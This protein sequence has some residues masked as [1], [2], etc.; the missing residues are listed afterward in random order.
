M[1]LDESPD[2]FTNDEQ[3]Y[4]T[5][6]GYVMNE[7]H[8]ADDPFAPMG[9]QP[10]TGGGSSAPGVPVAPRRISRFRMGLYIA[11]AVAF[12]ALALACWLRYFN[13]YITEAHVT[14]FVTNVEKRG[15]IFKTYEG[16]M[17]SQ[18]ALTDTVRIYT[19]DFIFSITDEALAHR[20]QDM[21]STGRPVT[22]IYKRY[23]AS[24]PWRGSSPI[25]VTGIY[26]KE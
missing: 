1:N 4:D 8:D 14:G 9:G 13:A 20:L 25:V 5:E 18:Q 16:E 2:N 10:R 21:Q 11:G 22:L 7:H 17:I 24:V 3:Q 6:N 26:T 23:H 19:R 15:V 12:A